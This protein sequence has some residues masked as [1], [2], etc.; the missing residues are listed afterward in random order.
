MSYQD[1][2]LCRDLPEPCWAE[3][4]GSTLISAPLPPAVERFVKMGRCKG[5]D[6][7]CCP[8]CMSCYLQSSD[9]DS[10]AN[11]PSETVVTIKRIP[12]AEAQ[13]LL[14]QEE[15]RKQ[16]AKIKKG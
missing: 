13:A 2:S 3:W 16:N 15:Q 12:D 9:T 11:A 5:G 4:L 10:F 8:E 14:F 1:C 6:V 7:L